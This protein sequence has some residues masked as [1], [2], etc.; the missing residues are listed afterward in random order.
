[1]PRLCLRRPR[2]CST[3]PTTYTSWSKRKR[4]FCRR[5]AS[6]NGWWASKRVNCWARPITSCTR[7]AKSKTLPV[8]TQYLITC[9]R[10]WR[11]WRAEE[12]AVVRTPKAW[13]G[14]SG[15]V[16][17][18]CRRVGKVAAPAAGYFVFL[19]FSLRHAPFELL[20]I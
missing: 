1:M 16:A 8:S 20:R 17:C 6:W 19:L 13:W 3:R 18:W 15:G 11:W 7:N 10:C 4:D 5:T 2:S 12:S 14:G 9:T